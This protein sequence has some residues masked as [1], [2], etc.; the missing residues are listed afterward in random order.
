MNIEN[1]KNLFQEK[2]KSIDF[3]NKKER[4]LIDAKEKKDEELDNKE[5]EHSMLLEKKIKLQRQKEKV[6]KIKAIKKEEKL[7]SLLIGFF[8]YSPILILLLV[9]IKLSIPHAL[10]A[11]IGGM[12]AGAISIVRYHSIVSPIKKIKKDIKNGKRDLGEEICHIENQLHDKNIEIEKIQNECNNLSEQ[13]QSTKELRDIISER[14][15]I[16]KECLYSAIEELLY[17]VDLDE[18]MDQK[19][20]EVEKT[21]C[22]KSNSK[23]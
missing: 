12:M 21:Y 11:L 4:K 8:V 14:L 19:M 5:I 9:T 16:Q 23:K 2:E 13:I 1:Y 22:K 20:N 7:Y 3:L 15:S 10:I 18:K 17:D 6:S